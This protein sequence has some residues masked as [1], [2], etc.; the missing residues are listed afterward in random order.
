[1][2]RF[3]LPRALL[4]LAA[5]LALMLPAATAEAV[6]LRV[7]GGAVIEGHARF[8][9]DGWLE[10]RAVLTDDAG[11]ALGDA[12]IDVDGAGTFEVGEVELCAN[13]RV[14]LGRRTRG[15]AVGVLT[16]PLGE[17]C[18]RWHAPPQ[19]GRLALR[20]AGDTYH[21]AADLGLDFDRSASQ[22]LWSSLRFDPAP[23]VIELDRD[24]AQVGAV[25]GIRPPAGAASREGLSVELRDRRDHLL[26]KAPTGGDGRLRFAVATAA[27]ADPGDD[28]LRLSFAG[29]A[30][31]APS[32][33]SEP[34]TLRA[35]VPLRL[36]APIGALRAG[37]SRA[38][39]VLL[40]PRRGVVRDGVVEAA[41]AELGLGTAPVHDG[42]AE[43]ELTL[44][45]EAGPRV[46][47]SFRY[48]PSAPCWAPGPPLSVAVELAPESRFGAVAWSVLV[49]AAAI[50]TVQSWRRARRKVEPAEAAA[51]APL[52]PGVHV[53]RPSR[54][55]DGWSGTVVDAHEGTP[56]AAAEIVVLGPGSRE[57]GR[58]ATDAQGRFALRLGEPAADAEIVASCRTHSSERRALP[59]PGTLRIALVTRRRSVL[60]R[61]VGWARAR[62]APYFMPPEPTPAD[63]RRMAAG[64]PP[65]ARWA[66]EVEAV[67][68]GPDEVGEL[69][70]QRVQQAEPPAPADDVGKPEAGPRASD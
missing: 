33:D 28:E 27:L 31:L 13:P 46:T 49:L 4:A 8:V 66:S 64:D 5:L 42:R 22:R 43:L 2:P 59:A 15:A 10:L 65:V 21:G 48:L 38:V 67:A 1:M 7:R 25:L 9:E 24:V 23:G 30:A 62:G 50:W 53:V 26:G 12:E 35:A 47:V 51:G 63:V 58:A 61:F 52:A 68:F 19:S 17:L 6:P 39:T 44:G 3:S 34:V 54:K 20:F 32:S 57:L 29:S 16:S 56:L 40:E 18:L 70:E 11:T 36:A 69:E 41:V 37:E 55:R 14:R 45:A 60:R